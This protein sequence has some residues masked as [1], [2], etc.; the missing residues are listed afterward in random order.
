MA[1]NQPTQKSTDQLALFSA[2]ADATERPFDWCSDDDQEA[3]ILE[4]QRAIA[5]YRNRS[6]G[7]VI[8]AERS[9]DDEDD[10]FIV[11]ATTQAVKALI[12][13]LQRE[14]GWA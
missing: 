12:A 4:E 1:D 8:R 7:V 14:I 11:L 6:N 10:A 5:V 2:P 9:L 13:A 3:I